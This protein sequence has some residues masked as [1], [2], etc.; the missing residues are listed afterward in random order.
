MGASESESPK[1]KLVPLDSV[2]NPSAASRLLDVNLE[3]E[4]DWFAAVNRYTLFR[5]PGFRSAYEGLLAEISADPDREL[6]EDEFKVSFRRHAKDVASFLYRQ[7]KPNSWSE[8]AYGVGQV[9]HALSGEGMRFDRAVISVLAF[10]RF[11]TKLGHA[12]KWHLPAHSIVACVFYFANLRGRLRKL[13]SKKPGNDDEK[14]D[15]ALHQIARATGQPVGLIDAVAGRM[16]ARE[17]PDEYRK[18]V[19]TLASYRT[20]SAI[21]EALSKDQPDLTRAKIED[22][23]VRRRVQTQP[24]EILRDEVISEAG[25][26][27]AGPYAWRGY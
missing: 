22:V 20:L 3:V 13:A 1:A 2:E 24:L 5:I 6:S 17:T 23:I 21:L 12:R 4:K 26:V 8:T 25:P 7:G 16:P 15:A 9:Q 10:N 14:M 18:A 11:S 19:T 27:T